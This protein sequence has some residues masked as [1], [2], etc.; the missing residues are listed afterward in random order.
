MEDDSNHVALGLVYTSPAARPQYVLACSKGVRYKRY[1]KYTSVN[2][3][4]GMDF[5]ITVRPV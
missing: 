3:R 2:L 1:R 4:Y 5:D